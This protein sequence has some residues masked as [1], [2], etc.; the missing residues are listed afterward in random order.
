MGLQS[1]W[2]MDSKM[3]S[4]NSASKDYEDNGLM[5]VA[6]DVREHSSH[7]QDIMPEMDKICGSGGCSEG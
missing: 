2:G 5:G 1:W 4:T 3:C 7:R 6:S